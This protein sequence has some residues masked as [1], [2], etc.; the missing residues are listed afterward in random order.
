MSPF[1]FT[2]APCTTGTSFSLHKPFA[3][4]ITA[5]ESDRMEVLGRK[6]FGDEFKDLGDEIL[7]SYVKPRFCNDLH[8]ISSEKKKMSKKILTVFPTKKV[9]NRKKNTELKDKD[10]LL[11]V[12]AAGIINRTTPGSEP[13]V[14]MQRTSNYRCSWSHSRQSR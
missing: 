6:K 10:K 2:P 11:D 13:H 8:P 7:K 5:K 14:K 9:V 1:L 3:P 12:L 4:E